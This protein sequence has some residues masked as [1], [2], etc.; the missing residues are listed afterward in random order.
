MV[1]KAVFFDMGGTIETYNTSREIRLQAAPGMRALLASGGF[2]LQLSDEQ[3]LDLIARGM[4]RYHGWRMKSMEELPPRRVWS[5]FIL[6]DFPESKDV[7]DALAEELMFYY[8]SRFFHRELRPE[9]PGVLETLRRMGFK[10]G[11]IS[12]VSSRD[13]VP[14]MLKAYGIHDYFDPIVLSCEY[15]RRKPDPAIFHYAARLANAPTGECVYVGDRIN[16]DILG[17]RKAGYRLAIQI[18][19]DYAHGEI[20]EGAVPDAIIEEMTELLEILYRDKAARDERHSGGDFP[21]RKIRAILFDAGDILYYRPHAGEALRAYVKQVTGR[22]EPIPAEEKKALSAQAFRGLIDQDQY[23]EGILRL[24]GLND[25]DQIARAKSILIEEEENIAFFPG[26]RE[27]LLAL[28]NA[29]YYLA[30]ITDTSQSVSHKIQ[31]LERGG[32]GHVWDA[33]ISSREVSVSKP[34]PRIFQAALSQLGVSP[35][36]AVFVG[37]LKS[38]LDGARAVGLITVGFNQ[39]QHAVADLSVT[40]F[41]ELLD[42]PIFTDRN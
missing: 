3:F 26:V 21:G 34:D 32:F 7:T 42:L 25:P 10:L 29:G 14:V 6:A 9:V 27:T 23:R 15:G 20:D 41:T 24:H 13:L 39:E 36:Q 11:V 18:L 12:N 37:H 19:H 5:E 8:G 38:E 17:A 33:I 2:N 28:K 40:A 30:I 16:R 4:Q 31:W 1:I 22:D 35:D